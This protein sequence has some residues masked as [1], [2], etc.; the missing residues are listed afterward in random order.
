MICSVLLQHHGEYGE[1]PRTIYAMLVHMIDDMEAHLTS[2]DDIIAD[3]AYSSDASG[4][5]IKYNGS[6]LNILG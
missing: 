3:H 5:K 2:I 4:T 6:Y 1:N